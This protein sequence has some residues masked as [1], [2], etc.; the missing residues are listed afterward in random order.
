MNFAEQSYCAMMMCM[1]STGIS[2]AMTAM[3]PTHAP[4]NAVENVSGTKMIT[5]MIILL[6]VPIAATIIMLPAKTADG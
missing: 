1:S 5:A 3:I 2:C 4:V 6:Y